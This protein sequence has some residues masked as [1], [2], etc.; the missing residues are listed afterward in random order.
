MTKQQ[1]DNRGG[2]RDGAGRPAQYGVRKVAFST[3]L[4]PQVKAFLQQ[5]EQS[6]SVIVEDTVRRSAAFKRWLSAQG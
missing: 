3:R 4:T 2:K 5:Q 6:G 1:T